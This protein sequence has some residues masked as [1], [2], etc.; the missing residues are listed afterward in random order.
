MGSTTPTHVGPVLPASVHRAP[1]LPGPCWWAR[2]RRQ[3]GSGPD[4][5]GPQGHSEASVA[6]EPQSPWFSSDGSRAHGRQPSPCCPRPRPT[7]AVLVS[8]HLLQQQG[9]AEGHVHRGR[10]WPGQGLAGAGACS[11][12]RPPGGREGPEPLC[13]GPQLIFSSGRSKTRR[14]SGVRGAKGATELLVCVHGGVLQAAAGGPGPGRG[15]SRDG[16]ACEA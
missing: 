2:G 11:P 16:C 9:C 1:A 4:P 12:G 3:A 13:R 14:S 10:A 8:G 15:G 6:Q 5:R 7:Q